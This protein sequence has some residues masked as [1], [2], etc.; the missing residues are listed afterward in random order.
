MNKI[1][2][3]SRTTE[4]SATAIRMLEVFRQHKVRQ[5]EEEPYLDKVFA[6]LEGLSERMTAAINKS[7]MVSVLET[8][9]TSRDEAVRAMYYLIQS[10]L[11]SP[12]A[13]TKSA[14]AAVNGVFQRYGVS[15]VRESYSTETALIE[16]LLKDLG[17]DE[18]K[19][20]L[21]SLLGL[22]QA[23]D[24]LRTLNAEFINSRVAYEKELAIV[25]NA[26]NA[27]AVKRE[28]IGL[29]NGKLVVYLMAM[30]D[31][32]PERYSTLAAEIAQ[33]INTNNEAIRKRTKDS[34]ESRK[35]N[36]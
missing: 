1:S 4:I 24:N 22:Q 6:E 16:S 35:F 27:T 23:V 13:R 5:P 18:L 30:N 31:A 33:V 10:H 17:A 29:I 11:N 7:R 2:T 32:E 25:A 3:A 9:D 14:A 26:E 19:E 36:A 21:A 28:M 34:V 15:I 20:A 8:N 12:D